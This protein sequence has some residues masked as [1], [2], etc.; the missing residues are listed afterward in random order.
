MGDGNTIT[1]TNTTISHT[2]S[3]GGW[4]TISLSAQDSSTSASSSSTILVQ[5]QQHEC[6]AFQ[7]FMIVEGEERETLIVEQGAQIPIFIRVIDPSNL[8]SSRSNQLTLLYDSVGEL[9]SIVWDYTIPYS[10][11]PYETPFTTQFSLNANTTTGLWNGT[12]TSNTQLN[13]YYPPYI[14]LSGHVA[15]RGVGALGCSIRSSPFSATIARFPSSFPLSPSPTPQKGAEMINVNYNPSFL[16][17]SRD[18]C[19][20]NSGIALLGDPTSTNSLGGLVLTTD[21][22]FGPS[23]S[24]VDLIQSGEVKFYPF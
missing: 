10:P 21:D 23:T 11:S 22:S 5:P 15:S 16:R 4:Y 7:I 20:I 17:I 18:P 9:P 1:T 6:Y 2:Y 8:S 13:G 3:S 12:L 24:L 19:S 14:T